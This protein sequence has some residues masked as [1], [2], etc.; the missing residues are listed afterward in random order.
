MD[1]LERIIPQVGDRIGRYEIIDELGRGGFGVV[2]RARQE[3]LSALVAIKVLIP[4]L[5]SQDDRLEVVKRFEQEAEVIRQLEHSSALKVRDIG[6]TDE[7]LPF[8]ATEF[9]RG[10]TLTDLIKS[11]PLPPKR[12][13]RIAMQVLGCLAEAHSKGIVHRDLKPDNLMVRDIVGETDAVKVLDFGIA[14][15]MVDSGVKTQ[16][17]LRFGTPRYMAP[18]Q[19]RGEGQVDGRLDLYALGLILAECASGEPV[20]N[21]GDM[22]AALMRHAQPE[23]LVFSE[24][25]QNSPLFPVVQKATSKDPALRY[26]DALAMRSALEKLTLNGPVAVP[27]PSHTDSSPLPTPGPLETPRAIESDPHAAH[28]L[29]APSGEDDGPPLAQRSVA[30]PTLVAALAAV[31][32]VAIAVIAIVLSQGADSDQERAAADTTE[33][34][35]LSPETEPQNEPEVAAVAPEVEPDETPRHGLQTRTEGAES[36]ENAQADRS[37][38]ASEGE[39]VANVVYGVGRGGG[40]LDDPGIGLG[41]GSSLFGEDDD[42]PFI[43]GALTREQIDGVVRSYRWEINECY[44]SALEDSPGLE[45]RLLVVISVDGGGRVSEAHIDTSNMDNDGLEGCLIRSIREWRFPY[46]A[47]PGS[48]IISYP[49]IFRTGY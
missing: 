17:G 38:D 23:A 49:F 12:I 10:L 5:T 40:S 16:T 48:V 37:D 31:F 4:P 13:V 32:V 8:M 3:G 19:A 6:H 29:A 9:V 14:K 39:A 7:G 22:L 44:D 18:E 24:A 30:S 1:F 2:Y 45:G 34:Q 35:D 20:V 21:D 42:D 47:S 46:P 41:S 36:E 26:P 43:M 15:V 33:E 28:T 11:G 27:S 25:V